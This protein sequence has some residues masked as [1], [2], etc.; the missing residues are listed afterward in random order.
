MRFE[1]TVFPEDWLLG[2][3]WAEFAA[4]Q[5]SLLPRGGQ[6]LLVIRRTS[7]GDAGGLPCWVRGDCIRE[8]GT[9]DWKIDAGMSAGGALAQ[10]QYAQERQRW[11]FEHVEAT[12]GWI[13]VC[14]GPGVL[15][16][17]LAG[18]VAVPAWLTIQIIERRERAAAT[19]ERSAEQ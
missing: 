5:V 2:I 12:G 3:W 9:L 15:S 17:W 4:G 7:P 14:G 10:Y 6:W 8:T 13:D 16:F 19:A 11:I 1:L 18:G